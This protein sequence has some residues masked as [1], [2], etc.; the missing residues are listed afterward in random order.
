MDCKTARL[1]L[2]F[3][4]PRISE[5]EASSAQALND[6]LAECPE[7]E[8]LARTEHQAERLLSSAMRQVPV[9]GDFR[10]RLLTRLQIERRAWYR[11]W[12]HRHPRI[13]A[14]LAAVVLLAVGLAVYVALKPPRPL[15]LQKMADHWNTPV[16]PEEVQ[17]WFAAKGFKIIVPPDFNYQYLAGYD[18]QVF[19]GQLVP[20]LEFIRGQYHASVYILSASQFDIRAAVDQPREGSGRFTVELRLGPLHSNVAYLIRYTGGSLEGFWRDQS[21]G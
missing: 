21:S 7:C 1:F 18:V 12:P 17:E 6:H 20:H 4:R 3:A 11:R 8:T 14:A 16:S 10:Q 15:D 13:V 2:A 9:P 5:L 19:D